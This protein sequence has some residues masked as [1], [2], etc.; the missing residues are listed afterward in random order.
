MC[1]EM[2]KAID[3]WENEGGR[4]ADLP[5]TVCTDTRA[6]PTYPLRNY[7]LSTESRRAATS[8]AGGCSNSDMLGSAR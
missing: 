3:R 2:T 5:L 1:V 8:D 7:F 4:T 6:M